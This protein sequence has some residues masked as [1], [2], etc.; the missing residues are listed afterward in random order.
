MTQKSLMDAAGPTGMSDA[1][2]TM[3]GLKS[4]SHGT[5]YNGGIAPTVTLGAGGGSISSVALSSFIPYQVQSGAWRLKF[6]IALNV[7]LVSR[8]NLPVI[9]AGIVY[10]NTYQFGVA[11]TTD[12]QAFAVYT[13]PSASQLQIAGTVTASFYSMSFDVLLASKPTWAY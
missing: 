13:E 10:A 3:L 9:I 4:Y 2:A 1:V 6:T 12:A 7:N 5:T 8:A 11:G